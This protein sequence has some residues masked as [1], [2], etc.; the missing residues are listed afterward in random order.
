MRK[1]MEVEKNKAKATTYGHAD[2]VMQLF[3]A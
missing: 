2:R 1:I 3:P